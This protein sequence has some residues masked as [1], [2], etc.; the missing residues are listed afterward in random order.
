MCKYVYRH[1]HKSFPNYVHLGS[2]AYVVSKHKMQH[3]L[4]VIDSD[5]VQNNLRWIAL[6][7]SLKQLSRLVCC[8]NGADLHCTNL[9]NIHCDNLWHLFACLPKGNHWKD[10]VKR[11]H[12][13]EIIGRY[14]KIVVL[15]NQ[16]SEH[17]DCSWYS[18]S[19]L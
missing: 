2:F 16:P 14:R 10:R 4:S 17:H 13:S 15:N 6:V 9:H 12:H 1:S 3:G 11:E 5:S 18:H 8:W 7:D 19:V